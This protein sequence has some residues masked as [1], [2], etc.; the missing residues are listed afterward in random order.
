MQ[1]LIQWTVEVESRFWFNK[2]QKINQRGR[3]SISSFETR[4]EKRFHVTLWWIPNKARA[5]QAQS[6]KIAFFR[7]QD[8]HWVSRL[9][10]NSWFYSWLLQK[11][12][13]PSKKHNF[14]TSKFAKNVARH[15]KNNDNKQLR[16]QIIERCKVK[17]QCQK[18]R[19]LEK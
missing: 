17:T 5:K 7:H 19:L 10:S 9:W 2:P 13:K 16:H 15:P 4:I 1:R 8:I 18:F 3:L 11:W 6:Q 14:K 12:A